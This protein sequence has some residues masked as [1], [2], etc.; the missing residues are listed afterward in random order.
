MEISA[1]FRFYCW[2]LSIGL[3]LVT[4]CILFDVIAQ[5]SMHNSGYSHFPQV[6]IAFSLMQV[7]KVSPTINS[8]WRS[9]L[10]SN[11]SAGETLCSYL[12]ANPNEPDTIFYNRMP[13][14]GSSTMEKLYDQLSKKNNFGRW[15]APRMFWGDMDSK[16]HQFETYVSQLRTYHHYIIDGHWSQRVFDVKKIAQTAEYVQLIRECHSWMLSRIDYTLFDSVEARKSKTSRYKYD[17]YIRYKL[18]SGSNDI[19]ECLDDLNCL[20]N[21]NIVYRA[22]MNIQYLC[23]KDCDKSDD[24]NKR[25][26]YS[27][28]TLNN[29]DKFTVIGM[30]SEMEKYL[31]VLECA[32][33]DILHGIT[34]TYL[35]EK[36]NT[37]TSNKKHNTDALVTLVNETCAQ[38]K[39]YNRVYR[40]AVAILTDQYEYL[41]T[42]NNKCCRKRKRTQ[43]SNIFRVT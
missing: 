40:E 34:A 28:S 2:I 18:N 17:E 9:E 35:K 37:R 36:T 38:S 41:L 25:K 14:A 32:Y 43:N 3:L 8:T 33:P 22:G 13:K 20:Q 7:K 12:R 19:D 39:E 23:D 16:M 42:N 27:M 1:K 21:S 26:L 29:P 31:Y 15:K 6:P 4:V 10:S 24:R 5:L 30:L 11:S